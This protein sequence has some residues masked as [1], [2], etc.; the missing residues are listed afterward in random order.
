MW[1][2]LQPTVHGATQPSFHLRLVQEIAVSG[3]DF[4]NKVSWSV[5]KDGQIENCVAS[6][7]CVSA[8]LQSGPQKSTL[9]CGFMY[10]CVQ[11]ACCMTFC[12]SV[13]VEWRTE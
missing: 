5:R 6:A 9:R 3:V 13:F 7:G 10:N 1:S 11:N 8:C 4:R 2:L 12:V